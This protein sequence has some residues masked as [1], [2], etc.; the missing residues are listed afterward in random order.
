MNYK[1]NKSISS[2]YLDVIYNIEDKPLTDYP[3]KLSKYLIDRYEI[4]KNSKI[5]DFGCGRG[6]FL[7]GFISQG[8]DGYGVDANDNAIKLFPKIKFSK[9]DVVTEG[10]PYEDDFFDVIFSKSVIEHFHDPDVFVKEI[11]RT[12]KPG[13][14]VIT[15]CPSWEYCYRIYFEDYTHRTPFMKSSLRDVLVM[16]G[17][18]EVEVSFFRQLPLAWG[19]LKFIFVPLS[20]IFQYLVPRKLFPRSKWVKFSK[21]IMLLSSASK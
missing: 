16:N 9:S 5:L 8:L 6:E 20:Y 14:L 1:D 13:G 15:L 3:D 2:N 4:D 10:L 7:N 18:K 11:Y 19:N 21:E 12:L 17:F